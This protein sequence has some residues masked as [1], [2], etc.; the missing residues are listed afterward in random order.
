MLI[1]KT[2]GHLQ[3]AAIGRLVTVC[4]CYLVCLYYSRKRSSLR[5]NPAINKLTA[6]RKRIYRPNGILSFDVQSCSVRH[7]FEAKQTCADG[8]TEGRK[9]ARTGHYAVNSKSAINQKPGVTVRQICAAILSLFF[10]TN[11]F[12]LQPSQ[13]DWCEYSWE[14]DKPVPARLN[15]PDWA[16]KVVIK[17]K[18][19]QLY[20]PIVDINPFF[21][22][23]DFDGD[24][25][26]DI[27]IRVK[28]RRSNKIGVLIVHSKTSQHFILGAGS[29]TKQGDDLGWFDMWTL[30]PK[31]RLKSP[32]EDKQVSTMG[33]AIQLDKSES[34]GG[35]FYWDGKKYEW[36]QVSD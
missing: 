17:S 2:G 24:H 10:F 22:T 9:S 12:A 32:Y 11:A 26:T 14:P 29:P 18:L 16:C 27:A 36:F 35:V 5:P 19:T 21:L 3:T 28:N 4:L 30:I 15:L 25:Q 13:A 31:T 34:A 7:L 33:D 23:G 20:S 8:M 1:L 6:Q